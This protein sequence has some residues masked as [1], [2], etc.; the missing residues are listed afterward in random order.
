MRTRSTGT[1]SLSTVR[2]GLIFSVEPIHALAAPIRP[3][4]RRNSSVSTAN[5]ILKS[6]RAA[7]IWASTAS[8]SPPASAAFA[9][10][11]TIRPVP[12]AAV[13][14]SRI[15]TRS[16]PLPSRSNCSAACRPAWPVP[17]SPSEMCTDA[18]S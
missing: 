4:R 1:I 13:R 16:P 14:E 2:I 18:M 15:R 11:R 17:D 8:R 10:A 12:P 5:H 9:A 3:P 6:A 7:S